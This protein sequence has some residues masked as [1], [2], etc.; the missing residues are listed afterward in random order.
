L[1]DNEVNWLV[2]LLRRLNFLAASRDRGRIRRMCVELL[3]LHRQ[4]EIEMPGDSRT[5]R[6]ARVIELRS[7]ADAAAVSNF[8]RRAEQSFAAW[9]VERPLTFRDIVLY[10]AV[11]ND[12]KSDL[13]VAGV[14]S[15][16]VDFALGI[17]P[18][19]IPAEL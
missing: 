16:I 7:G 15:R 5:A 10:V 14:R 12:L 9:P 2:D 8:M 18:E 17:V 1:Q 13:A 19:M 3:E 11:T 4:V 6:Y